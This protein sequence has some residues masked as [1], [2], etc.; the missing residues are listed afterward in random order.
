[1]W[2]AAINKCWLSAPNPTTAPHHP[3]PPPYPTTLPHPT[4]AAPG[5]QETCC[6]ITARSLVKILTLMALSYIH[7]YPCVCHK[8]LY[9]I[10]YYVYVFLTRG[11]G[12]NLHLLTLRARKL[13]DIILPKS[14]S[15]HIC[16][17]IDR[18]IWPNAHLY[19]HTHINNTYMYTCTY[20]YTYTH[21]YTCA[22]TCTCTYTYISIL[23][24]STP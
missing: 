13:K 23:S 17:Y 5:V 10:F 15:Q 18:H 16:I 21:T 8:L 14:G 9:V 4:V 22:C 7:K 24:S 12:R 2:G 20:T 1:M 6:R 11:T 19:I 3:T